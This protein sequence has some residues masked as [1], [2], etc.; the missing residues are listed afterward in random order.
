LID[1]QIAGIETAKYLHV[2]HASSVYLLLFEIIL[3]HY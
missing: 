3:L 2:L 1:T